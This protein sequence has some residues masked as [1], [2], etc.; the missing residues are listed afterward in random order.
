MIFSYDALLYCSLILSFIAGVVIFYKI[1]VQKNE[2]FK[3]KTINDQQVKISRELHDGVAQDLAAL[4]IYLNKSDKEKSDFYAD[5]ALKEV[6]Y[7]ID[8]MHLDWS[9]S[10]ASIVRE[11][12]ENFETNFG[13]KSELLIVSDNL[14]IIDSEVLVELLRVLQEALSNIARHSGADFVSV[15]ITEVGRDLNLIIKD[16]GKG[17]DFESLKESSSGDGKKH[18]GL[19]NI[20]ARVEEIGGK[21]EFKNEGGSTIAICIENIIR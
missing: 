6:R 14:E 13:I 19:K 5:Q 2:L 8:S 3:L 16:N 18:Y 12:L 4:K 7:L 15:K 20:V 10:F 9:K 1:I 17:I 21:V 11:N